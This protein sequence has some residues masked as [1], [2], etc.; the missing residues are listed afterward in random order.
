MNITNAGIKRRILATVRQKIADRS[1]TYICLALNHIAEQDHR[2]EIQE[3]CE[4]LRDRVMGEI[5]PW[6]TVGDMVAS[7]AI[8]MDDVLA[9]RLQVID[10]VARQLTPVSMTTLRRPVSA[11]STG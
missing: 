2:R 9:A 1:E 11:K 3:A 6:K 5:A 4:D 8:S 7:Q 10:D